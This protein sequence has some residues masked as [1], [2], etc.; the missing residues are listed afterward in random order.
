MCVF[1]RKIYLTWRGNGLADFNEIWQA[2]PSWAVVVPLKKLA[3][4]SSIT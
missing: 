2:G 1:V 3:L 4:D